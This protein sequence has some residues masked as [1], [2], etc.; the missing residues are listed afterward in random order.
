MQ[1]VRF[2]LSVKRQEAL[3]SHADAFTKQEKEFWETL[4]E[5]KTIWMYIIA[6]SDFLA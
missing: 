5:E 1:E 4:A 2:E 3:G 6:A